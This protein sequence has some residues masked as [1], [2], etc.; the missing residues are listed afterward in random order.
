MAVL[1]GF[2]IGFV[3]A[4]RRMGTKFV[5]VLIVPMVLAAVEI[6]V[7]TV[8]FGVA[9]MVVWTPVLIVLTVA[10]TA[11]GTV[12]GRW[13]TARRHQWWRSRYDRPRRS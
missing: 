11:A 1:A 3:A 6:V 13:V 7:N 12:A 10:A 9:A 5:V 2:L 4:Y 8:R